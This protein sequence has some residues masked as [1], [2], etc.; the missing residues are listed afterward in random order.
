[1]VVDGGAFREVVDESAALDMKRTDQPTVESRRRKVCQG[2]WTARSEKG[3]RG[4]KAGWRGRI[5]ESAGGE[6][7]KRAYEEMRMKWADEG[8]DGCGK[9]RRRKERES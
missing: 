7:N 6:A 3:G 9:G 8:G 4:D 5:S 1:M 2:K